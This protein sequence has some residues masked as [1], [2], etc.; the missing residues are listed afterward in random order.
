MGSKIVWKGM[1]SRKYLERGTM[2]REMQHVGRD[3]EESM[4]CGRCTVVV[5]VKGAER[6]NVKNWDFRLELWVLEEGKNIVS[7]LGKK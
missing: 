6:V 3:L 4:A 1:W 2:P 7:I 5:S